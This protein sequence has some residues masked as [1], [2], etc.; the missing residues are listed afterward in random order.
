MSSSQK[1][2]FKK[3]ECP[4][5]SDERKVSELPSLLGHIRQVTCSDILQDKWK[6]RLL[7]GGSRSKSCKCYD[8]SSG[9]C[10]CQNSKLIQQTAKSAPCRR[11]DRSHP[12][13]NS[14]SFSMCI[15]DTC[16]YA[17]NSFIL[18]WLEMLTQDFKSSAALDTPPPLQQWKTGC[19]IMQT[20]DDI[21]SESRLTSLLVWSIFALFHNA[22]LIFPRWTQ[23]ASDMFT[24][25]CE[26]RKLRSVAYF[27]SAWRKRTLAPWTSH[28]S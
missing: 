17:L 4:N 2:D 26:R 10:E 14:Q 6:R 27:H 5:S 21:S 23:Q 15:P 18:T 16:K 28:S 9:R 25:S 11:P 20:T 13:L 7:G 3:H 22:C 24:A 8:S 1:A 19:K 12:H